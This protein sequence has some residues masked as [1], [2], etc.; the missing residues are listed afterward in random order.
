MIIKTIQTRVHMFRS[1]DELPE[2]LL[3]FDQDSLTWHVVKDG[4]LKQGRYGHVALRVPC[5]F[6]AVTNPKFHRLLEMP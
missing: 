6:H 2:D 1:D 5:T 4:G 3:E